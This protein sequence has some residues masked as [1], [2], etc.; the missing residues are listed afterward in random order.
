MIKPR[1][2][3]ETKGKYLEGPAAR[4]N[5]ENA[6]SALFK[7]TKQKAASKSKQKGKD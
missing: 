2:K 1:N 6:M 7:A 5:F 4:K 3:N